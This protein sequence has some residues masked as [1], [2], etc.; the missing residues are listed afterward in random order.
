MGSGRYKDTKESIK[1]D[2]TKINAKPVLLNLLR[3]L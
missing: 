3:R 1:K 2:K